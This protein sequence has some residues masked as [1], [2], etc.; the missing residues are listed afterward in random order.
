MHNSSQE[1]RNTDYI[2]P[3]DIL[4]SCRTTDVN[5]FATRFNL[6]L[7]L[8]GALLV[9]ASRPLM[10]LAANAPWTGKVLA[11]VLVVFGL[12]VSAIGR[13]L[14]SLASFWVGYWEYRLKS[15]EDKV[16][17]SVR[18]VAEHPSKENQQALAKLLVYLRYGGT[19]E[20]VLW[21][22]DLLIVLW[23]IRNIYHSQM[24]PRSGC[25]R[26]LSS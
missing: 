22:C 13:R 25:W 6:F 5:L 16:H 12:L 1:A 19:R 10:D 26:A 8:E 4:L 11:S 24:T 20:T 14:M 23:S 18:I 2:K 9:F 21:L 3:Y 15:V 17:L 7:V